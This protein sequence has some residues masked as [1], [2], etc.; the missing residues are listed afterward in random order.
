M[1]T[2]YGFAQPTASQSAKQ[3]NAPEEVV[4]ALLIGV[5]QAGKSSFVNWLCSLSESLADEAPEGFEGGGQSCTKT[6]GIY[7]LKIQLSDYKLVDLSPSPK[8]VPLPKSERELLSQKGLWTKLNSKLI[9]TTP[10]APVVSFRIIDTPGLDDSENEDLSNIT[11]VMRT[12]NHLLQTDNNPTVNG[13]IFVMG[14]SSPFGKTFQSVYNYY[15]RC[16]PDLFGGVTMVNTKFTFR[17]WKQRRRHL[18]ECGEVDESQESWTRILQDRRSDFANLLDHDPPHWLVDSKPAPEDNLE[19]LFSLN[20]T[21]DLLR[22]VASQSPKKISHLRY[23]KMDKDMAIDSSIQSRVQS[24]LYTWE[25]FRELILAKSSAEQK[26]YIQSQ[27]RI[28]EVEKKI[29]DFDERLS[30]IEHDEVI[31]LNMRDTRIP[32]TAS[33][34]TRVKRPFGGGGSTRTLQVEEPYE[35]FHVDFLPNDGSKWVKAEKTSKN[36]WVGT[37]K[38][39]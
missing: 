37:Y 21:M 24:K 2:E 30:S 25:K 33:F 9:P 29:R 11:D 23:Q 5:T 26:L 39:S 28:L 18:E 17:E 3:D 32:D 8:D 7:E 31:S 36:V 27:G 10:N 20:H 35:T 13:L 19:R 14:V 34:W 38:S 6:C 15:R 16:V 12:L 4:T 22:V 1:A